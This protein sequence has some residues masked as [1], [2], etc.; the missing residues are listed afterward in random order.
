MNIMTDEEIYALNISFQTNKE[1]YAHE[2]YI[3]RSTHVQCGLGLFTK[4]DININS[5]I[6]LQYKGILVPNNDNIV[7]NAYHARLSNQWLIDASDPFC[8]LARYV[9]SPFCTGSKAN[10]KMI[11]NNKLAMSDRVYIKLIKPI[12]ANEELFCDY[13]NEYEFYPVQQ[14]KE[15]VKEKKKIIQ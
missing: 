8:C 7:P 11:W 6:T 14:I 5:N 15:I 13:H 2:F 12:K 9:N 1:E 4:E 10:C 3:R